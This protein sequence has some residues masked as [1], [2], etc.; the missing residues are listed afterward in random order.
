MLATVV[1]IAT[2]LMD[3]LWDSIVGMRD[4][5]HAWVRQNSIDVGSVCWVTSPELAQGVACQ[6]WEEVDQRRRCE[7]RNCA[8]E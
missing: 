3:G 1:Q 2:T 7:R 8:A 4:S 5:V 6:R